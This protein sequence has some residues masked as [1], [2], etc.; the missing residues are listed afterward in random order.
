MIESLIQQSA[1]GLE[2]VFENKVTGPLESVLGQSLLSVSYWV[3]GYDAGLFSVEQPNASGIL[4]AGL[5]FEKSTLEVSWGWEKLLRGSDLSYHIQVLP[6]GQAHGAQ[7][8]TDG[9]F[10]EIKGVDATLW[11]NAVGKRLTGVEVIGFQGSPQ[12]VRFSFSGAEV[13][14]AIGYAG[15]DLLVGDGDDL[16]LFSKQEWQHQ[17]SSYGEEWEHLWA[18]SA[19]K[20]NKLSTAN[21][22]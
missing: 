4:V 15:D 3:L 10:C 9:N 18:N 13:V 1:S 8:A 5:H 22:Q 20:Q 6:A 7:A 11:K 12:A 19:T 16:L 17:R 21:T 14:I 2:A